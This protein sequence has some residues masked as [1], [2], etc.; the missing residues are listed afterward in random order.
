M[1][2]ATAAARAGLTEREARKFCENSVITYE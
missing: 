2:L 1:K